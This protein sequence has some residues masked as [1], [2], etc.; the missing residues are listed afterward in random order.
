M[1]M[2]VIWSYEHRMWWGPN[3]AGYVDDLADA[4]RYTAPEAGRIVT[5]S[6]LL[7]ELAVL[8]QVVLRFGGKPPAFHPYHGPVTGG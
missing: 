7:E 8:E 6:V 2:Y 3:H 4:G 5:N 1:T